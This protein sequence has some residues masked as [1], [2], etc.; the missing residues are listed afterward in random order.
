[1][2]VWAGLTTTP[3]GNDGGDRYG[4][5]SSSGWHRTGKVASSGGTYPPGIDRPPEVADTVDGG[6]HVAATRGRVR[7][8][9]RQA[10]SRWVTA[11]RR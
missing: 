4:G 1:V 5:P 11:G 2:F 7:T 3:G 8:S 6:A 10:G 9:T